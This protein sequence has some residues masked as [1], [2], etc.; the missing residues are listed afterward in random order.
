MGFHSERKA[1]RA[2]DDPFLGWLAKHNAILEREQIERLELPPQDTLIRDVARSY[3]RQMS[4]EICVPFVHVD[5]SEIPRIGE[6][7]LIGVLN[8]GRRAGKRGSFTQQEIELLTRLCTPVTLAL[9]NALLH[10][11]RLKL[12]ENQVQA[13]FIAAAS[14]ALAHSIKNPLGLLDGDVDL[15]RDA[16]A[17]EENEGAD[18]AVLD[19]EAQVRKIEGIVNQ[20]RNADIGPPDLAPCDLGVIIE[21]VLAEV[22]TANPQSSVQV[23]AA[24]DD[25]PEILGDASQ[26]RLA[27][28]NLLMNAYQAMSPAGG[29]LFIHTAVTRYQHTPAIQVKVCDTGCGMPQNFIQQ[30]MNR[31][32]ITRKKT[33]TGLGVWTTKKIIEAH[34]GNLALTS[35]EGVGTTA[36]VILPTSTPS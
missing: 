1:E 22:K 33:G 30:I 11:A 16:L 12:Q 15:L 18:F 24:G 3:F 17:A 26:L 9:E 5:Q 36:T 28:T 31:P 21:E 35:Q 2:I 8:L 34:N 32:F 10:E 27:L 14:G 19:I 7:Q 4:A 29:T 6:G 20:I 25:I 13:E 23:N